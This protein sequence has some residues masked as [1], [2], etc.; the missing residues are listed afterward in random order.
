MNL[1]KRKLDHIRICLN[2]DVLFKN[3]TTGFEQYDFIHCALPE[4]DLKDVDTEISFLG[5]TLSFPFMINAMTGGFKDAFQINECFAQACKIEK[6]G[7]EVGSQRQIFENDKY[8]NTYKIVRKTAPDAVIIGNI[9]AAQTAECYDFDNIK[10]L[11][12]VIEADS[13]AVHLN[14][15]QEVLQ[16]EGDVNFSGV[17]NGIEKLVNS[18]SVP[19]IVKETGCGISSQIVEQLVNV[20]VE[21]IDVAGAGGTSWAKVESFRNK[22]DF[23]DAFEDWGIPTAECLE[24]AGSVKGALIIASGGVKGGITI[25][26]ALALGAECCASALPLLKIQ[27]SSGLKGL[28]DLIVKWRKELKIAMFL[29][30]S[31]SVRD[32]KRPGLL[33]KKGKLN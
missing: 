29:T 16:P 4:M 5:K 2:E 24:M 3:K 17:L 32:L 27:D 9:G 25:A 1:S 18:L 33:V 7:L 20:G 19:V 10:K 23:T 30:G 22:Q 15:L 13:M 21:Y 6:I 12:D 11:I 28:V 31:R 26:K 8:I 14:P